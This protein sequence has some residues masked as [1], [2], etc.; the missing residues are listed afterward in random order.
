MKKLS[1]ESPVKTWWSNACWKLLTKWVPKCNNNLRL[2]GWLTVSLS[3][4]PCNFLFNVESSLFQ[5]LIHLLDWRA[6]NISIFVALSPDR[7]LEELPTLTPIDQQ[8]NWNLNLKRG[9]IWRKSNGWGTTKLIKYQV[10]AMADQVIWRLKAKLLKPFKKNKIECI[11]KINTFWNIFTMEKSRSKKVLS[12]FPMRMKTIM[13]TKDLKTT[14]S[15]IF[16]KRLSPWGNSLSLMQLT[17]WG[18]PKSS[19]TSK[20]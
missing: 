17:I 18:E 1:L 15:S 16:A 10:T 19:T 8:L 11:S 4:H 12:Q 20:W 14:S 2:H 7:M 13:S 9:F 5:K 3:S 6:E